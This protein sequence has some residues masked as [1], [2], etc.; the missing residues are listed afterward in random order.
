MQ[1]TVHD[2]L[3]IRNVQDISKLNPLG[4]TN[5]PIGKV[6]QYQPISISDEVNKS[7]RL[8]F[9]KYITSRI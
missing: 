6:E 8:L 7:K 2:M 5:N 9:S 4:Y 1:K 3:L